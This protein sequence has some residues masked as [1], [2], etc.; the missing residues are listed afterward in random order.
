MGEKSINRKVLDSEGVN[1]VVKPILNGVKKGGD[2]A[3]LGYTRKFDGCDLKP[4][5]LRVTKRDIKDAYARSDKSILRALKNAHR[6]IKRFHSQQNKHIARSWRTTTTEGVSISE[7]IT[8][9]GSV[10]CYIP[11]GLASYPSTVL[12]TCIP[13]KVAGVERVILVSPPPIADSVLVAA[14]I[15]GVQE[16]YRVGGAQAIGALAFGTESIPGVSKIVGPGNK[17]VLAAKNLVYGIV[18][19]DMPAG[20]SEVLII[21]DKSAKPQLIA[22][23][24]L[25]QA[26][27]D[28]DALCVLVTTS[29]EISNEVKKRIKEQLGELSRKKII[30][31]SIKNLKIVVTKNMKDAIRFTNDFAP[32]HLEIMTKN[33]EKVANDIRNAGSIF[34]GD[35]SP[36]A[37]GDYATGANHVLPTSGT[38]RFSSQLS[39]RDFLKS[40]TVQK[41]SRAGLSRLGETIDVLARIEG[42]DAHRK[43]ADIRLK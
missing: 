39:V 4:N 28:P 9:I 6:N 40:H 35:Y 42:L 33:P 29:K 10:G 2:K 1:K 7:K 14:D 3:L 8:P 22:S 18:D 16:I 38:A 13:A 37:A 36:V 43:S 26:E 23:D 19:I 5:K 17:Y 31:K 11:G 25:A 32:E 12:M 27:H 20:P 24:I 34:L 21:A 15:A 30:K 41:I